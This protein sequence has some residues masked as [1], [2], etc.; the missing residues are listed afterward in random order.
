MSYS[1]PA[2]SQVIMFITYAKMTFFYLFRSC[3][4]NRKKKGRKKKKR[5]TFFLFS[6]LIKKTIFGR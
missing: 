5:I 2:T 1:I 6:P 3:I 4:K